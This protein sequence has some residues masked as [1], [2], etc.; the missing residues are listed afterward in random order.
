MLV[1][2]KVKYEE[3]KNKNKDEYGACIFRY[4]ERWADL[5]E[6]E[7]EKGYKVS[8]VAERLSVEADTENIT[9]VM[10]EVANN[11][12]CKCWIYGSELES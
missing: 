10:Q 11:I 12:L 2:D 8:D 3:W 4:A 6:I 9:G 1:K 7:I 5:M